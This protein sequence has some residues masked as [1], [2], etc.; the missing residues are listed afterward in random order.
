MFHRFLLR[1]SGPSLIRNAVIFIRWPLG[2]PSAAG[3]SDI[4]NREFLLYITGIESQN[5]L[6]DTNFINVYG[7][8]QLATEIEEGTGTNEEGKKRRRRTI[9]T[10]QEQQELI[11][12]RRQTYQDDSQNR[13]FNTVIN[14]T[15][16]HE[17][18][19]NII[20]TVSQLAGGAVAE[21]SIESRVFE[22]T[23]IDKARDKKWEFEVFA[24]VKILDTYIEQSD[25]N[26][27]DRVRASLTINPQVIPPAQVSEFMWWILPVVIVGFF[28]LLIPL[29]F[30]LYL[31][32][33]FKLK[34]SQKARIE[35]KRQQQVNEWT[36]RQ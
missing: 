29:F 28:L 14:C 12:N 18:C 33:F 27:V 26:L 36:K 35:K 17:A 6:C 21:M 24:D 16:S 7:I 19:V 5:F 1:N 30:L 11:R 31:C 20:C 23:L 3:A 10:M 25:T 34:K 8:T 22:A 13:D 32:G 15:A 2:Y 9:M 4:K